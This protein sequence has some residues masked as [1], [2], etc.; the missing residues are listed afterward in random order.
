MLTRTKI[1]FVYPPSH[2]S[3][4]KGSEGKKGKSIAVRGHKKKKNIE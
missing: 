4:Q 2:E 3:N 1:K